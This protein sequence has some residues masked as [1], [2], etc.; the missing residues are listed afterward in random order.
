MHRDFDDK[1]LNLAVL[2]GA[3]SMLFFVAFVQADPPPPLN[4]AS[5]FGCYV[6]VRAA[7]ILL[8]E[9]GLTVM[10]QGTP[11]MGFS[12]VRHKN[13]IDLETEHWLEPVMA[14]EG[15]VLRIGRFGRFIPFYK[16]E[17]GM[18]YGGF[19]EHELNAFRMEVSDGRYLAFAKSDPQNCTLD[20]RAGATPNP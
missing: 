6:S 7:P 9:S 16:I 2:V 3:V 20:R 4:R 14:G 10:Q 11:T 19:D 18:A 1:W 17:R 12:L 5:A 8:N 13:G 15:F